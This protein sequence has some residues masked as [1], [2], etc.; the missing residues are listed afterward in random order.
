MVVCRWFCC[1]ASSLIFYPVPTVGDEVIFVVHPFTE[2]G[3]CGDNGGI[4]NRQP[5]ACT[6]HGTAEAP[7]YQAASCVS[8]LIV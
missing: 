1:S 6:N 2:D 5:F 8:D 7:D 4:F 3:T